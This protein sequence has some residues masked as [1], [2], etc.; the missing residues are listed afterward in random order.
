MNS[1]EIKRKSTAKKVLSSLSP[2]CHSYK[3]LASQKNDVFMN[4]FIIPSDYGS[5]R[6][7]DRDQTV[8]DL[9]IRS[10]GEKWTGGKPSHSR[11]R[12]AMARKNVMKSFS[13]ASTASGQRGLSWGL[14]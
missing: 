3:L 5:N 1:F 10:V 11:L 12:N 13:L 6:T 2:E 7:A 9:F 4:T 14:V 8:W